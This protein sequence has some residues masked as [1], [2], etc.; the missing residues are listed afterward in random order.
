MLFKKGLK[1]KCRQLRNKKKDEREA[2]GGKIAVFKE[3][4]FGKDFW[5]IKSKKS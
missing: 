2:E 4:S 5:G 1:G 3:N